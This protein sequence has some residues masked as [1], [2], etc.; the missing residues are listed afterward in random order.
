[1]QIISPKEAKEQRSRSYQIGS[2][3]ETPIK[4]LRNF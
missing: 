3:R 1:M 4:L 2:L